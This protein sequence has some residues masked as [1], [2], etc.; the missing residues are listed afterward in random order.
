[1]LY[2]KATNLQNSMEYDAAT[3]EFKQEE[4]PLSIGNTCL[5]LGGQSD[6]LEFWHSL[7]YKKC[8][9]LTSKFARSA[10]DRMDSP[11]QVDE[12]RT[13]LKSFLPVQHDDAQYQIAT[14]YCNL[15]GT[16]QI[17]ES[18]SIGISSS[19]SEAVVTPGQRSSS[20]PTFFSPAAIWQVSR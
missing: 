20:L 18:E 17:L 14:I 4:A 9:R 7:T 10:Q 15:L 13:N 1:M 3:T 8:P 16:R 11:L 5:I 12:R 6:T 2:L 19:W